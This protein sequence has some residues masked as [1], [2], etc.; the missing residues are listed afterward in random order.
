MWFFSPI[1]PKNGVT[2]PKFEYFKAVPAFSMIKRSHPCIS[3]LSP[4]F[5]QLSLLAEHC[6]MCICNTKIRHTMWKYAHWHWH[7]STK[8]DF[9]LAKLQASPFV[10]FWIFPYV[11]FLHK[12][13]GS[14]VNQ[15]WPWVWQKGPTFRSCQMLITNIYLSLQTTKNVE[16]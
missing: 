11:S 12:L 15:V 8:I 3:R 6:G 16:F 7:S 10:G 13:V 1:F 2:S 5:F 14:F 4:I 9:F